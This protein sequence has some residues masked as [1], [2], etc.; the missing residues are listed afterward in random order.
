MFLADVST[1][2][3]NKK[4]NL[5]LGRYLMRFKDIIVALILFSGKKFCFSFLLP[6]SFLV[7]ALDV[8][9]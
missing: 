9:F 2:I 1:L 8:D 3:V 5:I 4:K 6:G 7:F